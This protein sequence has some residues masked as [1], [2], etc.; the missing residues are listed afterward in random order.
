MLPNIAKR[1][2]IVCCRQGYML[3]RRIQNISNIAIF[4][5][6]DKTMM[7]QSFIDR[8]LIPKEAV[9]PASRPVQHKGLQHP[10]KS[11]LD[12]LPYSYPLQPCPSGTK[13]RHGR[14]TLTPSI[15]YGR[16]KSSKAWNNARAPCVAPPGDGLVALL[17][18]AA[19]ISK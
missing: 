1:S 12:D 8:H 2:H 14:L 17:T 13:Q 19:K 6:L 9:G 7:F 15:H 4:L 18:F 3:E 16:T 5:G 11:A 10:D